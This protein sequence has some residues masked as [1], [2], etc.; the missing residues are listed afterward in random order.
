MQNYTKSQTRLAFIQFIF[1]LEFSNIKNS[2]TIEDFQEYFYKSNIAS[3]GEKKEFIFKFNKNFLK[4]LSNN[5]IKNF[6]KKIIVKQLNKHIQLDRKFEK[7]DKVLKSL[8]FAFIS[9]MQIADNS[10][11]KIIINDY[12]NIAKSLVST[13]E[14]KLMNAIIQKYIDEKQND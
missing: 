9:E 14:I 12:I 7:W 2:E 6:D 5:Y 1:Q 4:K 10:K 3:I 8:I 13:K 11:I